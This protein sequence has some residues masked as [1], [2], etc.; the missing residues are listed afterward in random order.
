MIID[1][2]SIIK[3]KNESKQLKAVYCYGS[4][5]EAAAADSVTNE[6]RL[7]LDADV[8]IP[9]AYVHSLSRIG[10]GIQSSGTKSYF[11]DE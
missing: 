9:A 3:N 2:P 11:T 10:Q 7:E 1:I 5:C 6:E 8:L 4:V